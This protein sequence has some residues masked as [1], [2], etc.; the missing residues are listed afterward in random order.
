MSEPG[1]AAPDTLGQL[2][3]ETE[4]YVSA[5]QAPIPLHV[6]QQL[7]TTPGGPLV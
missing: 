3:L 1:A 6:P 5:A 2:L 7:L 4:L